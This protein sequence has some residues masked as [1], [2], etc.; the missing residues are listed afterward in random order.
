MKKWQIEDP[1]EIRIINGDKP[2]FQLQE[3]KLIGYG[4]PWSG[5]E[6]LHINTKCELKAIFLISQSDVSSI[7]KIPAN[8][9]L[10]FVLNQLFF[11]NIENGNFILLNLV[12]QFIQM[13]PIFKLY[14]TL[15]QSSA[16]AEL[17]FSKKYLG[18]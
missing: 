7:E 6:N 12:K 18:D 5:K 8:E 1:N 16:K 17:L 15:D 13:I 10:P 4:T 2:L 14:G 11:P 9:A 3:K